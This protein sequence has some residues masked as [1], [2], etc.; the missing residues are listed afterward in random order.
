MSK[1]SSLFCTVNFIDS[2]VFQEMFAWNHFC[3]IS[4]F[5]WFHMHTN[6]F[7]LSKRII[8]L[9]KKIR[10]FSFFYFQWNRKFHKFLRDFCNLSLGQFA[11]DVTRKKWRDLWLFATQRKFQN[12][13]FGIERINFINPADLNKKCYNV[14]SSVNTSIWATDSIK[15]TILLSLLRSM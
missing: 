15:R 1:H 12:Q 10:S 5:V 2:K 6:C 14:T 13:Q 9:N 7:M 8:K 4:H 11:N 3:F